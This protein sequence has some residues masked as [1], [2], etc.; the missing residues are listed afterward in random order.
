[1][2]IHDWTRVDAGAFHAFHLAWI[3]ALQEVLNDGLLPSGFYVLA[4]QVAGSI[5]PDVLAPQTT[6]GNGAS[7]GALTPETGEGGTTTVVQARPRTRFT[8]TLDTDPYAQRRRS[9]V[10]RHV[11]GDRIIALIE[12]I[13]PGNKA[14]QYPFRS[15][16]EKAI[17]A[18]EQGIH[19]M[20]ID[21]FP[22]TP[23]DPRG[24]HSALWESLGGAQ[25]T[26]PEGEPLMVASYFAS[27]PPVAFLEPVAVSRPLPDTDLF[28][29][30]E[31][32]VKVPLEATY[33]RAWRGVPFPIR[34][35]LERPTPP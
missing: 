10:I 23:R 35:A 20:L 22:P 4:E 11:S 13:S 33:A 2:P 16:L 31:L 6:N 18:L 21:L 32:L 17:G 28:L 19:L 34:N 8:A 12:L 7:G 1:M 25:F 29:T 24:L 14:A 3:A 9:L 15:L 26:A 27:R 5:G 30:P